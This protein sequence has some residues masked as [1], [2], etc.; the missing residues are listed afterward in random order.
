[1]SGDV[2]TAPQVDAAHAFLATVA[3]EPLD[4]KKL[5]AAA[6]VGV[7]VRIPFREQHSSF[8]LSLNRFSHT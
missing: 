8:T 3:D 4:D 5:E 6:G 1:M 7:K 2:K